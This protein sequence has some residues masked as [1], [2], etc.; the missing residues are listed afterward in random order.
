MLEFVFVTQ[1]AGRMYEKIS[2]PPTPHPHCVFAEGESR[3]GSPRKMQ[4][5]AEV[6]SVLGSM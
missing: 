6:P 1:L 4:A 2:P 3:P 5:S